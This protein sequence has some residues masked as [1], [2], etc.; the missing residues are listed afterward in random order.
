[1]PEGGKG[2]F[3]HF[4]VMAEYLWRW[5][6]AV[7]HGGMAMQI[8]HMPLSPKVPL[9]AASGGRLHDGVGPCSTALPS[10]SAGSTLS[11]WGRAHLPV[12]S[13]CIAG[14]QGGAA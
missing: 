11:L 5:R 3:I 14:Q 12:L 8:C 4:E 10:R 2:I 9:R 13:L 6:R 1:M 7:L